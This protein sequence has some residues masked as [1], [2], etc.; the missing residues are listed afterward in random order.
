MNSALLKPEERAILRLRDLYRTYGYTCFKMSKFEAYELYVENKEFLISDRVITFTDTD[1]KLMALKPDVTLSIVKNAPEGG[2]VSRVYYNESVFRVSERTHQFKELMQTGLECIGELGA[3][4]LCEVVALAGR[5]LSTIAQGSVLAVSH[6]GIV[7][8]LLRTV[9]T[10]AAKQEILRALE[11]K[12]PHGMREACAAADVDAPTTDALVSL[13]DMYGE[14]A[15]VLPRLRSMSEDAEVHA[16]VKT[17]E[18]A[19]SLCEE[20]TQT[21]VVIDLSLVSDTGYYNGLIF[22]GYVRGIPTAVL[23]GGQYD[24]LM[25]RMGKRARAIGFAVYLD[26]LEQLEEDDALDADVLLLCQK[27]DDPR[28]VFRYVRTLTDKGLRVAVDTCPDS[29][30]RVGRTERFTGGESHA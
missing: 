9:C 7:S 2:G 10:A 12:N 20:D 1:G 5:S 26:G 27:D 29:R 21:R 3:Y 28:A 8:A 4:H 30:L 14:P 16:A 22:R 15:A 19:V 17:L 11:A 18:Q 23:F 6:L 13:T 25:E 24:R